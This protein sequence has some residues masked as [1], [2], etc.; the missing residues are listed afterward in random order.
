MTLGPDNT[1]IVAD[2]ESHAIRRID[3]KT[4]IIKESVV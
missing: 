4:G 2:T 1:L 3:L